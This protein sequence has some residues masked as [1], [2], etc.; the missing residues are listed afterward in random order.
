M[1]ADLSHSSGSSLLAMNR[2]TQLHHIMCWRC[3]H[4][5][6]LHLIFNQGSG[7]GNHR[8]FNHRI[9]VMNLAWKN[10]CQ[11]TR[12]R[13]GTSKLGSFLQEKH[14]ATLRPCAS[15]DSS[16]A[17]AHIAQRQCKMQ[18]KLNNDTSHLPTEK[19]GGMGPLRAVSALLIDFDQAILQS[20]GNLANLSRVYSE[21]LHLT[22]W[23]R[24][25]F[26]WWKACIQKSPISRYDS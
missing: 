15:I 21:R 12:I 9:F 17:M 1:Q 7:T 16:K 23:I 25:V 19:N 10:A 18:I 3:S 14:R 22:T 11:S 5:P 24:R 6:P 4:E 26:L 20:H 8:I 2:A 13:F